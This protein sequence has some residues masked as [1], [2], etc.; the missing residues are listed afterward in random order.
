VERVQIKP[1]CV[2]VV[3]RVEGFASVV[4]ELLVDETPDRK[5]A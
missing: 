4:T 3:L 5:A 1:D 2:E